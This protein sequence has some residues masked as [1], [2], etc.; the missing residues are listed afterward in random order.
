MTA[1]RLR[2]VSSIIIPVPHLRLPRSQESP[3]QKDE[4]RKT[5]PG[6]HMIFYSSSCGMRFD[7]QRKSAGQKGLRRT[8]L[9][10]AGAPE[11]VPQIAAKR[12]L[13]LVALIRIN[14]EAEQLCK[15]GRLRSQE[16]EIIERV[17]AIV[18]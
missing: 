14:A 11:R 12:A 18:L 15:R 9:Y 13:H 5:R 4:V 7:T 2:H 8:G 10:G 3:V 1:D 17:L 6:A 16:Q